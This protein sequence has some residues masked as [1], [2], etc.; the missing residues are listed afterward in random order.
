MQPATQPAFL[1]L[2]SRF[3]RNLQPDRLCRNFFPQV[4]ELGITI[5]WRDGRQMCAV[6]FIKLEDFLDD[7]RHGMTID[8]DPQGILFA[9]VGAERSASIGRLLFSNVS[10]GWIAL[11]YN[12]YLLVVYL[13]ISL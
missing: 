4:R 11:C 1:K 9:E 5:A 3:A 13:I 12:S 2:V 8:L 6:K 10:I 7:Q